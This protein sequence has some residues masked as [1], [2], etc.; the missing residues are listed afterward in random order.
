MIRYVS[1]SGLITTVLYFIDFCQ[2]ACNDYG[3]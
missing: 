1:A 2:N 3:E